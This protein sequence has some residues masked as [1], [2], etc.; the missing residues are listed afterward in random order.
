M[1]IRLVSYASVII[2]YTDL[3][4]WTDPWLFGKVVSDLWSMFPQTELDEA[5]IK[6]IEW[7]SR[8]RPVKPSLVVAEIILAPATTV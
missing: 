7:T 2:R 4:M 1:Q 6:G 3:R 5:W 8:D